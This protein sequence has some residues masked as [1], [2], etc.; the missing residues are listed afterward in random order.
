MDDVYL[1]GDF[2]NAVVY[3]GDENHSDLVPSEQ[4]ED[5]EFNIEFGDTRFHFINPEI[6]SGSVN[7]DFLKKHKSSY[8]FSQNLENMMVTATPDRVSAK[9]LPIL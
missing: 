8:T 9:P 4:F 7:L 5:P 6:V 2:R 3:V 1:I